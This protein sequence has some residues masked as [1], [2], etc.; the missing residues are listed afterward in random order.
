MILLDCCAGAASATFPTG[1]SITETI[2]ASSWDAIAPDPGRYSFTNALI[3]VLDEWRQRTFSAAMLHAEILARLKHPRPILINGKHFEARSTPVHFM[4]TSNHKAPSIELCRLV[5]RKR[6]PPSPPNELAYRDWN[7]P[8][9]PR[10]IE[11]RNPV[12]QYPLVPDFGIPATSEPN[13]DEPHVLIS[14]ALEDDQRLDLNDW[15]TWLAAFPSI[16]KYVKVQ[17]VFKSHST[18]L[19]LSLPVMV[20]DFLPDDPAC[21]FVA[22]IRS[23]NLL[24]VQRP[25]QEPERVPVAQHVP[26]SNMAPDDAESCFSGTT[27]GPTESLNMA[28]HPAAGP[29]IHRNH[30]AAS[31]PYRDPYADSRLHTR[32]GASVGSRPDHSAPGSFSSPGPSLRPRPQPSMGSLRSSLRNVPSTT[33]LRTLDRH[34]VNPGG[35]TGV[36]NDL[37]APAEGISRTM[38]LNRTRTSKK[39]VFQSDQDV[40][41]GQQMAPHVIRRLEDYFQKDSEPSVAIV[42][43]LAS[44]LG[45]ET[46]DIHVR[47]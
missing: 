6:L 36:G 47:F 18:M 43:H 34:H 16:A 1:K 29:I 40:P 28:R 2:S 26:V 4:M 33:S 45:V 15:E 20:W 35:L 12:E 38:I 22:F 9:H 14:L 17:G 8:S 24:R 13:E 23:N 32:I 44:N 27:Y 30:S 11:G 31:A 19:L 46:S 41:R 10:M 25:S 5:P 7:Q 37:P 42:E 3:E 21:S 39:S